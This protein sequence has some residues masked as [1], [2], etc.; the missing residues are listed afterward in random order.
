[1]IKLSSCIEMMYQELPFATRIE[2]AK[3]TGFQAW[4]FWGWPNRDIPALEEAMAKTGL[5]AAAC[6]VGSRDPHTVS[7]MKGANML[8]AG[9]A[10]M[11]ADMVEETIAAVKGLHIKTLIATTGNTLKDVSRERQQEAVVACLSA[12]AP[13]LEKSGCVIVLEPLNILVNHAGYYLSTSDQG[14]EILKQVGSARVKLLYDVYHQ[15]ITEGNLI[16]VIRANIQAIGHF[17]IAD[18]PGRH[19][20]GTGEINYENIFAAISESGYNG[21]VGCE[22]SPSKGKS[23]AESA[24]LVLELANH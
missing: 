13:I 23:S 8:D 1:V 18:V 9:N 20:P 5:P 3:T 17:H 10:R 16:D 11:F 24:R 21:Y 22:Y 12:A 2:A 6:C 4:E 19:E 15:Q 7:A 14:F